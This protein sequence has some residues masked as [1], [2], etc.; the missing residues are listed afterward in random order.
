MTSQE[1]LNSVNAAPF[2]AFQIR[3][4]TGR[5]FAIRHPE[6]VRVGRRD[7][8]VFTFVSDS[9]DVYD[10]WENVSFVLIESLSPLEP[11]VAGT[12]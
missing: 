9:A 10:K 5:M 7:A 8:M 2:R 6:M 3:M 12:N 4:I 11:S 1:L